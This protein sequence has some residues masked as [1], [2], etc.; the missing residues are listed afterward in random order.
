MCIS[1]TWDG[2][3]GK[4]CNKNIHERL[5]CL[6]VNRRFFFTRFCRL[7]A[8]RIYHGDFEPRNIVRSG[9]RFFIIDFANATI[10]HNC[11][12]PSKCS[13]LQKAWK[14]LEL[15][16]Q[17]PS[18]DGKSIICIWPSISRSEGLTRLRVSAQELQQF[19]LEFITVICIFMNQSISS[20]YLL[21]YAATCGRSIFI[22]STNSI[23]L[24]GNYISRLQY[25]GASRT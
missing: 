12:G 16:G 22:I 7:H 6:N 10:G 4:H 8:L 17:R 23:I 1:I 11:P 21:T 13:G 9:Q 5:W 25:K 2:L 14:C 15:V 18:L 24:W 20:V 3:R 19:G